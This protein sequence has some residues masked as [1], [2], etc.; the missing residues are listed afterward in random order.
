V[1]ITS[2]VPNGIPGRDGP[3]GQGRT[4]NATTPTNADAA[5]APPVGRD[6]MGFG[7][8]SVLFRFL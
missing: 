4:T 1:P 3:S 6:R 5:S 7:G 8:G 2:A